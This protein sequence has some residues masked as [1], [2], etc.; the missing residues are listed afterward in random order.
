MLENAKVPR[1]LSEFEHPIASFLKCQTAFPRLPTEPFDSRA[2]SRR[3]LIRSPC[4]KSVS[5]KSEA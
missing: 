3:R 2:S 5:R 4:A 1:V